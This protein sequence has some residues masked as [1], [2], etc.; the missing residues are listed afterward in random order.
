LK[1]RFRKTQRDTKFFK[2]NIDDA[3]ELAT[4][5]GVRSIPTFI[6]LKN[7]ENVGTIMGARTEDDFD[8]EVKGKF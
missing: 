4:K 1:Q 8:Q 3:Q 5:F 6:F 2:V 7:S